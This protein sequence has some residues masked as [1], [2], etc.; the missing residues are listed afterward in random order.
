M[1][2]PER[3]VGPA[4]NKGILGQIGQWEVLSKYLITI[5]YAYLFLYLIAIRMEEIMLQIIILFVFFSMLSLFFFTA[6]FT[7]C[8]CRCIQ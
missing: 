6:L 8:I 2:K 5:M 7:S 1:A 4:G 3:K